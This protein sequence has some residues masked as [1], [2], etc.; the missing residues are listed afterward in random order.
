MNSGW[1]YPC[2]STEGS[3][4]V[5]PARSPVRHCQA[6]PQRTERTLQETPH[7]RLD[8]DTPQHLTSFSASQ[9]FRQ[10]T[11]HQTTLKRTHPAEDR[12]T[13]RRVF[14]PSFLRR[15]H[16]L[17]SRRLSR[18]VRLFSHSSPQPLSQPQNISHPLPAPPQ[19]RFREFFRQTSTFWAAS[20]VVYFIVCRETALG[21]QRRKAVLHKL[22]VA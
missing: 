6:H 10:R 7:E 15:L 11:K 1:C 22:F 9:F 3:T 20:A 5:K 21:R 19:H 8:S 17:H 4:I 13:M 14:Q 2:R 16:W 12:R 18:T